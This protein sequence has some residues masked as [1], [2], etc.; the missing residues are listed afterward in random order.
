MS[1]NLT[2]LSAGAVKPALSR[3]IETFQAE[4]GATIQVSFA[5]A[6]ELLTRISSSASADVLIA[7]TAVIKKFVEAGTGAPIHRVVLGRIGAGVFVRDEVPLP[8]L[9]TVDDFRRALLEADSVVYN[10]ASTGAYLTKLFDR[11]GIGAAIE[12]KATRYPDFA[13]VLDHVAKGS[14]REIGLGATTV[15]IENQS[16]GI[17]FA[18]P[19]PAEIQNYTVYE[20][21]A[22][23][24]DRRTAASNFLGYIESGAARKLISASGIQ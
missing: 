2:V 8:Q 7:P 3:L 21:A 6:P 20:A 19:L 5:T 13:A 16:R 24:D 4:T 12:S 1:Q 11:L 10:Q 18:G 23:V 9:G 22:F 15:I 14:G 17:R